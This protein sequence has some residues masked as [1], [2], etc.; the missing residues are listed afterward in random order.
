MPRSLRPSPWW[1]ILPALVALVVV[2]DRPRPG[3]PAHQAEWLTAGDTQLRAVRAGTGDT[4]LLLLHGFG[5]SL[6]T[7]RSIFDQLATRHRVVAVDLPG[8]GG[9]GKPDGP[10]TLDA[11]TGRLSDFIDRWIDGPLLVV[12]HSMG[13]ELTASLALARPDRIG[14]AVLIAPAGWNVGLGGIADTMYPGKARAIGWY[15]SSRAFVLP[16]HD[17]DWLGEPDSAAAYT[18]VGDSA[19]RKAAARV[20]E[21]FDF[22]G[23]RTRLT[24]VRQPVLLLWGT[25]D[26]VIP[27]A[28][29]D[30]MAKTLPCS[31]LT[32][33]DGAFH[34]PQA[35]IPDPVARAILDFAADPVCST[36]G[37][38]PH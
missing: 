19:Y 12:G 32:V 31:R 14:A 36:E 21:E 7:W 5:E 1:V 24:D 25:R 3:R 38:K 18:L 20:L 11:M 30:S 13:G 22:R 10:Y 17:P 29:A 35:E 34:R 9:S 33:F 15:L 6:F 16:E 26:P 37:R 8:F 2:I 28:I 4:T 23:L 27:F